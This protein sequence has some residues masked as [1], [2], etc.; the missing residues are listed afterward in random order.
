MGDEKDEI[1]AAVT[2]GVSL[3]EAVVLPGV[4]QS[5]SPYGGMMCADFFSFYLSYSNCCFSCVLL[6]A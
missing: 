2:P 6:I 3:I 4:A 1:G 5:A